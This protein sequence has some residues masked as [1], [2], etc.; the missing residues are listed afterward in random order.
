[1]CLS[2]PSRAQRPCGGYGNP[3]QMPRAGV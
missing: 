1:M 2:G 3:D